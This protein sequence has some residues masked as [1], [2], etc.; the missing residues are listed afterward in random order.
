MI[1]RCCGKQSESDYCTDECSIEYAKHEA[2][3]SKYKSV[4]LGCIVISLI[5]MCAPLPYIMLMG[6]VLLGT[7]IIVF[8][9]VTQSTI[10]MFGLKKSK[11]ISRGVGAILYCMGIIFAAY[12]LTN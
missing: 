9:F 1:C 11:K 10:D 6:F 5:L 3:V 12:L 4:C 7:T 2:F 8:P